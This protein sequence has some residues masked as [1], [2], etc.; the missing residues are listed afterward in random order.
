MLCKRHLVLVAP[1]ERLTSEVSPEVVLLCNIALF[2]LSRFLSN[3]A[4]AQHAISGNPS[5]GC[6][7][8]SNTGGVQGVWV[9]DSVEKVIIVTS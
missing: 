2:Y 5:A 7:G 6:P 3:V 1:R 4:L 9:G 8:D